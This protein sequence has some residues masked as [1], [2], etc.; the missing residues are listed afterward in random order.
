MNA[1]V[2]EDGTIKSRVGEG[3]VAITVEDIRQEFELPET[4]NLDVSSH[5]FNKKLLWD[6]IKSESTP[7][8]VKFS[9]KKKNLYKCLECKIAGV[10]EIKPEKITTLHAIVSG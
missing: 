10:D 7:T 6:E 4:S 2:A 5:S 1:V 8:Y 9:R 3:E